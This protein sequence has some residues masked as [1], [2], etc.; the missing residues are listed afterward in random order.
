VDMRESENNCET[1]M[2]FIKE[3]VLV[4]IYENRE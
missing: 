2:A 3:K 4:A 1:G